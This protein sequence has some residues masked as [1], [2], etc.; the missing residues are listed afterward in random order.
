MSAD[1]TID[2]EGLAQDA[3]RGLVRTILKRV[4]KTGLPG[5][6]HFY[7][8]FYTQAPGVSVSDRLKEKYPEEMTIVM[9]HRFWGL[10]VYEDRFEIK[11]TFDSIPERLVVPYAAI[12]VFFDPSVPYG[13]QFEESDAKNDAIR[14]N[15][16]LPD[17]DQPGGSLADLSLVDSSTKRSRG[18]TTKS[19]P[20]RKRPAL[21]KKP[22]GDDKPADSVKTPSPARAVRRKKNVESDND[23]RPVLDDRPE[24][25]AQPEKTST[26]K[27][28]KPET[29]PTAVPQIKTETDPKEGI[30]GDVMEP[31]QES[32]ASAKVVSLD[33]F[34]KK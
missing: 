19:A 23:P 32:D 5:D 13:L 25:V 31:A 15:H 20:S 3:M 16:D 9:Q 21:S 2:Y 24:A 10:Q 17:T 27:S 33:A 26:G 7:I 14:A 12:K 8:A 4:H 18:R 6:H 1:Q 22:A 34:R 29:T 28:K 30:D 11:L